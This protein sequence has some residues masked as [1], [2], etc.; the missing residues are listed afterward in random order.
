MD[1]RS[2]RGPHFLCIGAQKAGTTWL[3]ANL[4]AHPS[5]WLPSEKELHYFDE[6]RFR[7]LRLREKLFARD[8]QA[9]RWRRQLGRQLRARRRRRSLAGARWDVRYFFGHTGDD[10]YMSLFE[11]GAGKLTGEITPAYST[12]DEDGVAHVRRLAPEIR[13]APV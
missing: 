10:W 1:T 13:R 8:D 11:P 3:Y 12:L 2:Q 6:K 4:R 7:R 9:L 5:I